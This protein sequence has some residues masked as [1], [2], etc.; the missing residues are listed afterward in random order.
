[1]KKFLAILSFCII[2]AT[3]LCAQTGSVAPTR[4]V[5]EESIPS[6]NTLR[7]YRF[8]IAISPESFVENFN[9]NYSAVLQFWQECEDFLN[10]VY[11][12]LG[13][14]FNVLESERLIMDTGLPV[15]PYSGIPEIGGATAL[16]DNAIGTES[17]DIGIWVVYR[18]EGDENTGLSL[19]GGAYDNST[20]A[21]GYA[22][23]DKW[24]VAHET[25]HLFGAHHTT[26]GEGSLMDN[27]GE[28]FSYPSI[29]SIRKASVTAGPGNAY[30]QER[31][32]NN[33]PTFTAQMKEIYRIPQG[34]CM[35]IPVYA[36][37]ADG[38]RLR[39]SAI[40]CSSSTV[41]NVIENG[42]L[43]HFASLAPQESNIIDYSPR[44]SADIF[45]ED[46]YYTIEGSD[47]PSMEPGRY[48][49]AFLVNDMPEENSFEHL[50]ATP[51]YSNYAV[52]D[53]TVEI[54]GGEEFT[55]TLSPLQESY[56]AG[57]T[58]TVSWGVN[59]SCFNSNSRVR[60]TMSA[61]YGKS[62]NYLLAESIPAL[63]GEAVVTL[64]D[65]NVG[66]VDV[67]FSTAT[68]SMR[69][70][71]IRIEEINGV[72]YTLTTLTPENGGGFNITGGSSPGTSIEAT[73]KERPGS[74]A[75]DLSGRRAE[76]RAGSGLYI[77][78]GR[79]H[80]RQQ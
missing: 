20:K 2:Y 18:E 52:W 57:S 10:D 62:F 35:A 66:N 53:A 73:V 19:N 59:H 58:I 28:F 77:I 13:F 23:A 78:N 44:F 60:I 33:S 67:D 25:G 48:N 42:Y 46:F 71:I 55:A 34:A 15:N 30:R 37:D 7:Y 70:G 9:S 41:E 45:Y 69:G 21:N 74:E 54:M 68:R 61:D 12:P 27:G 36:S 8:A 63:N 31:V 64:P 32:A 26:A 11:V 49:I 47:I 5:A 39:Y 65:I 22:M 38:H 29:K 40:G 76:E 43:P 14:C 80:Y 51:F 75:Y 24:V 79:K 3:G 17:Y 1:M 56:T 72:A 4:A 6:D 16:I 50:T